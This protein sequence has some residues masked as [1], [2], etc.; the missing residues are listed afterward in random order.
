MPSGPKKKVRTSAT[1]TLFSLP[2]TT[3]GV[4]WPTGTGTGTYPYGAGD[5]YTGPTTGGGAGAG[6]AAGSHWPADGNCPED[7]C[8]DGN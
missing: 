3:T 5:G 2:T 4:Y 6:G 8:P 7:W 1:P